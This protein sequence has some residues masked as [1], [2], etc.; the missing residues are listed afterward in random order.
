MHVLLVQLLNL[1]CGHV[2]PIGSNIPIR[3]R[4]NIHQIL[5]RSRCHQHRE[6]LLLEHRQPPLQ[7][8]QTRKLPG[9]LDGL[10]QLTQRDCFFS[11]QRSCRESRTLGQLRFFELVGIPSQECHDLCRFKSR[12]AKSLLFAGYTYGRFL[13]IFGCRQDGL[14]AVRKAIHLLRFRWTLIVFVKRVIH[15]SKHCLQRH[16]G[17]FPSLNQSPVERRE[18]QNS[19]PPPLK[20]LFD[21]RKVIE[22]I[23]HDGSLQRSEVGSQG[24]P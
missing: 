10:R 17:T 12:L 24:E 16:A 22:V 8:L 5:I 19:A 23:F 7:I 14:R 18:E 3:F 15:P 4:A 21:F 13:H 9:T 6:E 11:C 2:S 20:V 1:G